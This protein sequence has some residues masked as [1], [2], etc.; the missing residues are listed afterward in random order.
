MLNLFIYYNKNFKI[1]RFNYFKSRIKMLK[2]N[3]KQLLKHF[4]TR[5]KRVQSFDS[6]K[7]SP[8][9]KYAIT[10]INFKFSK[11]I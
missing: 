9:D 11:A 7:F 8:F 5:L 6:E 1:R 2:Q 4:N 10:Q 3:Q